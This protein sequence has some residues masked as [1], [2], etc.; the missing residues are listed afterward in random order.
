ML[1]QTN[2]RVWESTDWGK[3]LL[4]F[5][6]N[7]GLPSKHLKGQPAV[8]TQQIGCSSSYYRADH[9]SRVAVDVKVAKNDFSVASCEGLSDLFQKMFPGPVTERFTLSRSKASYLISNGLGPIL[10]KH[11]IKET[12]S[13]DSAFTLMYNETTKK[14]ESRWTFLSDFGWKLRRKLW[15]I[16]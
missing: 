5:A 6:F 1:K 14:S 16:F 3:T 15:F 10:T 8:L 13:T 11:I 12:N 9:N 7:K 2:I 4:Q